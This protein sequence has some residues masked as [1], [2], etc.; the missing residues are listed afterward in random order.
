MYMESIWDAGLPFSRHDREL[1]WEQ[2]IAAGRITKKPKERLSQ[3]EKLILA[4]QKKVYALE[5][6]LIDAW[7]KNKH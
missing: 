1:A 4:R 6:T 3:S 7:K 2:M 5:K